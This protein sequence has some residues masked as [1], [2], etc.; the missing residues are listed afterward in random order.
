[1]NET[2]YTINAQ[3]CKRIYNKQTDQEALRPENRIAPYWRNLFV[4]AVDHP[5]EFDLEYDSEVA[6]QVMGEYMWQEKELRE[7]SVPDLRKICTKLG[8]TGQGKDEMVKNILL[9]Q[10]SMK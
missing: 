5:Q 4:Y 7:K 6:K 10:S 1:M 8:T 2:E 9:A 3:R